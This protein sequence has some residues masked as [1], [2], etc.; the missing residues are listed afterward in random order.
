MTSLDD[1][2]FTLGKLSAGQDALLARQEKRDKEI[3]DIQLKLGEIKTRMTPMAEGFKW[4]EP[5]VKSYRRVRRFGAWVASI[6]VAIGGTVGGA[7]A[8]FIL[9][10]LDGGT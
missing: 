6:L 8:T 3:A 9:K 10:K 4:M 2:S 7:L 1:I 5:E